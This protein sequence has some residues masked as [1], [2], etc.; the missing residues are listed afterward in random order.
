[1]MKKKL[2]VLMTL[3]AWLSVGVNAQSLGVY[4]D[5]NNGPYTNIRNAPKGKV[6]DKIPTKEIAMI[7]VEKPTNG[8]WKIIGTTYDTGDKEGVLKPSATGHWI[9]YSVLGMGTRNYGGQ[10]L[11]LRKNPS[12][13]APVVY[14]FKDEILLRP[15]DIKGD[16][17]KVQTSDGKYTGWIEE[18]W[19]C[20]NALTTCC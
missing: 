1:M 17:V 2:F 12:A 16:W 6:I 14:T 7:G 20:G 8:W 15:I 13:T 11:Y 3:M 9:H 18:E 4:I 5:D 19:L 10:T